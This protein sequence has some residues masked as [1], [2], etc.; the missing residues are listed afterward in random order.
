MH[1][2]HHSSD[3]GSAQPLRVLG[4]LLSDLAA[5]RLVSAPSSPA[6]RSWMTPSGTSLAEALQEH[7]RVAHEACGLLD[8]LAAVLTGLNLLTVDTLVCPYP[9][10]A[11]DVQYALDGFNL[12]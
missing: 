1:L 2:V 12:S 5:A 10:H 9:A 6:A 8:G 4:C 11:W 7:W 3:D